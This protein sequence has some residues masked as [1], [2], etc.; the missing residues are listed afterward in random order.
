MLSP[1]SQIKNTHRV[2]SWNK[3]CSCYESY[4]KNCRR[5]A[6]MAYEFF[7][8]LWTPLNPVLVPVRVSQIW[9]DIYKRLHAKRPVKPYSPP[10]PEAHACWAIKVKGMSWSSRS[11]DIKKGYPHQIFRCNGDQEVIDQQNGTAP[12]S[13]IRQI[14]GQNKLTGPLTCLTIQRP[15]RSATKSVNDKKTM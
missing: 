13:P 10:G 12:Q 15:Y 6:D 3:C 8:S 14:A 7:R 9:T 11:R 1:N 5:V 4:P 2:E